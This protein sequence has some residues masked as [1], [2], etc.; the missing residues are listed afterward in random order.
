ME[1]TKEL[2]LVA[3]SQ[4]AKSIGGQAFLRR[5]PRHENLI[6]SASIAQELGRKTS[7]RK[8]AH[9]II[10][11]CMLERQSSNFSLRYTDNGVERAA[12]KFN[13]SGN[14]VAAIAREA[15]GQL[16]REGQFDR[17]YRILCDYTG[18]YVSDTYHSTQQKG[19]FWEISLWAGDKTITV[20][21][22]VAEAWEKHRYSSTFVFCDVDGHMYARRNGGKLCRLQETEILPLMK[23][24]LRKITEVGVSGGSVVGNTFISNE[25][26]FAQMVGLVEFVQDLARGEWQ[27]RME[28]GEYLKAKHIVS[29]FFLKELVAEAIAKE[30]ERLSCKFPKKPDYARCFNIA[31]ECILSGK[32]EHA[33]LLLR[34]LIWHALNNRETFKL[35][36]PDSSFARCAVEAPLMKELMLVRKNGISEGKEKLSPEDVKARVLDEC[37]Q[38]MLANDISVASLL[39]KR[40]GISVRVELLEE[41]REMAFTDSLRSGFYG[42]A[43]RFCIQSGMETRLREVKEIAK[44]LQDDVR[45]TMMSRNN[46]DRPSN[47]HDL[48][49]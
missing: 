21:K 27:K 43:A 28:R 37:N 16:K 1:K 4:I 23:E 31:Y 36:S 49:L 24:S 47:R 39:A 11:N 40:F 5:L 45:I 41:Y 10:R 38:R 48:G 7:M 14:D 8:L 6:I 19:K 35:V 42:D 2:P 17:A 32:K 15:A 34:K 25:Y 20:T 9:R 33:R 30:A 18:T 46:D 29:G 44:L 13:V 3:R 22:P 12:K 26:V